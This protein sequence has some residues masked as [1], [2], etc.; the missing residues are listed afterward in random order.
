V[1]GWRLC[2]VR[3]RDRG[4]RALTSAVKGCFLLFIVLVR[5]T[6]LCINLPLRRLYCIC[7]VYCARSSLFS[8]ATR[9]SR[10]T[11]PVTR[12]MHTTLT[13][14]WTWTSAYCSCVPSAHYVLSLVL[15]GVDNVDGDDD[16]NKVV[17]KRACA[18][19]RAVIRARSLR[20]LHG[21]GSQAA[22]AGLGARTSSR[23][24]R[25]QS[26]QGWSRAPPATLPG[27]TLPPRLAH[28]AGWPDFRREP[29]RARSRQ[30]RRWDAG[31]AGQPAGT[32]AREHARSTDDQPTWRAEARRC[33]RQMDRRGGGREHVCSLSP[34]RALF[35][36]T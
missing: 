29:E 26:L 32:G 3:E 8:H 2:S 22:D 20:R 5:G 19:C 34:F 7:D 10:N 1:D 31:T 16:S 21:A 27:R 18:R 11:R 13:V 23:E 12:S 35:D 4:R 6:L 24:R 9:P 28:H 30:Q 33:A 15:S 25:S 14:T 36:K 17:R